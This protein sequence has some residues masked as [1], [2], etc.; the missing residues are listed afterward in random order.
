MT[1][2]AWSSWGECAGP[3]LDQHDAVLLDLDGVVYVGEQAVPGAV[4]AIAGGPA[5]G[6]RRS[7]S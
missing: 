4:E 1:D 6:H 7:P 5:P 2:P 3:L